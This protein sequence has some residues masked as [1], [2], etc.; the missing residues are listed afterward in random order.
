MDLTLNTSSSLENPMNP[1]K[2]GLEG[3][4]AVLNDPVLHPGSLAQPEEHL[5]ETQ[6][7]GGSNPPGTA[8]KKGYVVVEAG[9]EYDD[10]HH[11]FSDGWGDIDTHVYGTVEEARVAA[12]A[13][14][15]ECYDNFSLADF[16]LG[17][18]KH[19]KTYIALH[20]EAST[21]DTSINTFVTWA[22]ANNIIWTNEMPQ[23]VSILELDLPA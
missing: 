2:E 21:Y 7:V 5:L 13:H 4:I 10:E 22:D 19:V 16:E 11:Y 17:F 3:L 1:A 8:V 20:P 18:N 23:M 12:K 15:R 6:E 14:L 9:I